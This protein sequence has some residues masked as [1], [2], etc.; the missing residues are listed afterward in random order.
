MIGKFWRRVLISAAAGLALSAQA[1]RAEWLRAETEHFIIYGDS[2]ERRMRDYARKVER[3]DSLLRAYY[4]IRTEHHLPK[5]EIFLAQGRADMLRAYPGIEASVGGYYSPNSGRIHAVV[6]RESGMGD[7]VLFHEYGHHFMFQMASA[8]YPAWFVEGFA[9][10]YAHSEVEGDTVR[11]GLFSPGRMN[12]LTRGNAMAPLRDVIGWRILKSGR[13]PGHDYYAQSW[14]LT[15]YMLS[16]P[17]RAKSLGRYL[18]AVSRGADPVAAV[19]PELGRTPERL[20]DELRRYLLRG[21]TVLTP[22]VDLPD[23]DVKITRLDAADSQLVWLDLRLDRY[24]LN[25]GAD[26]D[27]EEQAG[28]DESA[29]DIAEARAKSQEQRRLLIAQALETASRFPDSEKAALV[30]ARA[31]ILAGS[32]DKALERLTPWIEGDDAASSA[33]RVGAY[34]A[35]AQARNSNEDQPDMMRRAR[36]YLSRGLEKDPLDSRTYIALDDSRR[37]TAGYP[38]ANDLAT[39]EVAAALA[40]QSF[41]ARMRAA[42]AYLAHQRPAEA[43]LM[44][45]PVVNS[46]HG[47]SSS[48]QAKAQLARAQALVQA[49]ASVVRSEAAPAAEPSSPTS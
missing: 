8:A 13:Y 34:A 35:M 22:Q 43:V 20:A 47:G 46:P 3:F 39:L 25:D 36:S 28:E 5:L 10:Y 21:I 4:P 17:E 9:E 38:T 1:A 26:N 42:D 33:L 32:P 2:S 12:S 24:R 44:L 7:A 29:D 6:N 41:D 16:D 18:A 15:H 40:P 48:E 37:G 31:H 14:A 23:A 49:S 19:E 11:I 30:A 45:T 27:E